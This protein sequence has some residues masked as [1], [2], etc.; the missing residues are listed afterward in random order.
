M[1]AAERR[2]VLALAGVIAARMLGLFLLLPVLA[3]YA[4]S[5]PGSTPLLVGLAVGVYGLTQALFQLGFGICSD[6]YGRKGVITV[7]LIIFILGSV[8]AALSDTLLWLIVGRAIQGAGAVSSAVLALAADL[9]REEQ[10]TKVMALIGVSIGA[11]FLLSM[12]LAPLLSRYIGVTGLFWF[13]AS[14]GGIALWM[15]H[16]WVPTPVR[17]RHHHDVAPTMDRIISVWRDRQ[18]LRLNGGAFILHLTLTALF[19]VLPAALNRMG[20]MVLHD[21]WKVYLPVLLVSVVGMVPLVSRGGNAKTV[22]LM[23][24]LAI[25]ILLAGFA[26]LVLVAMGETTRFLWLPVCMCIFFIGFNALEAMLPSL[27]SRIAPAVD[28]GTAIGLFNTWQFMGVFVGG[29]LGGW[30]T[31]Q[32]GCAAVYLLCAF[33]VFIW[34]LAALISPAFPLSSSRVIRIDDASD[35][36][37]VASLVDRIRSIRG[38]QEVIVVPEEAL[39]YLK[40][41]DRELDV[42]ALQQ[43]D[44]DLTN[45]RGGI[46]NGQQKREQGNSGGEPWA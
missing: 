7:G 35:D 23:F 19:V 29:I 20:G 28:K 6:R 8:I 24:R 46:F 9:S 12:V 33:L 11:M 34:L 17:T 5:L 31:G 40:V 14:L 44:Q 41:D 27:V 18:L 45:F 2:H 25:G 32:F 4:T 43:L 21:H 22:M 15:L 13:T 10:R 16:G 26:G 42:V 38:V 3:L 1:N 39:A 37:H 36:S 30:I